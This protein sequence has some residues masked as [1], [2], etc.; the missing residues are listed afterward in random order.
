[1]TP[2][3]SRCWLLKCCVMRDASIPS[4]LAP[5]ALG[6]LSDSY[7]IEVHSDF[8]QMLCGLLTTLSP[9][10]KGMMF[11]PSSAAC[12]AIRAELKLNRLSR[13]PVGSSGIL[14]LIHAVDCRCQSP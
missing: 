9:S 6:L 2:G 14:L 3:L 7:R 10:V 5:L 1:M 12:W 13:M 8:A 4:I 11:L